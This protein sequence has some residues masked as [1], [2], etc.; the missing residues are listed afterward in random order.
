MMFKI[1]RY[2][3]RVAF[4]VMHLGKA[5]IWDYTG[6]NKDIIDRAIYD[7]AEIILCDKVK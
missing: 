7:Y 3:N 4:A 2:W 5:M 1:S 6:S